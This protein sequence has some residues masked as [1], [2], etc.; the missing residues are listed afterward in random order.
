M[1]SSEVIDVP[2]KLDNLLKLIYSISPSTKVLYSNIITRTDTD[3]KFKQKVSEANKAINEYSKNVNITV[4]KND[5]VGVEHLARKGAKFTTNLKDAIK[6]ILY[7]C[8][9]RVVDSAKSALEC[10]TFPDCINSSSL[11]NKNELDSLDLPRLETGQLKKP[12]FILS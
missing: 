10:D 8:K 11:Q 12:I 9:L 1:P 3:N 4:I 7:F 5:N 2:I 6:D